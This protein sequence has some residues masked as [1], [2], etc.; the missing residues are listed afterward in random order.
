MPA[1]AADKWAIETSLRKNGQVVCDLTHTPDLSLAQFAPLITKNYTISISQSS[2][3]TGARSLQATSLSVLINNLGVEC[4][5][6]SCNIGTIPKPPSPK[7]SSNGWIAAVVIIVL[8]VV[9]LVIGGIIVALVLFL[10]YRKKQ[11]TKGV[12]QMNKNLHKFTTYTEEMRE[13]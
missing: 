13:I 7:K 5:D 11:R 10:I 12:S 8:L 3:S 9:A 2:E 1:T 4:Q 6:S